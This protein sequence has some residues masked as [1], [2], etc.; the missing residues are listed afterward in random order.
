MSVYVRRQTQRR[1]FK[2]A[3]YFLS[4]PYAPALRSL[5]LAIYANEGHCALWGLGH[6]IG[7]ADEGH[8]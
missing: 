5:F 2:N 1:A 3:I 6:E 7:T 8:A 4:T